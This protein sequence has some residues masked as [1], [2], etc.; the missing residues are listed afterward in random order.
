MKYFVSLETD[1]WVENEKK[2]RCFRKNIC[3][4]ET[5]RVEW[6]EE[7]CALKI[8]ILI[9]FAFFLELTF[10]FLLFNHLIILLLFIFVHDFFRFARAYRAYR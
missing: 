5:A 3:F 6:I 10:Y 2:A 8:I 9:Y 7:T 1:I 4:K